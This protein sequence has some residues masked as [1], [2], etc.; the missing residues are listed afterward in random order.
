[1]FNDEWGRY[2]WKDSDKMR[3]VLV[4]EIPARVAADRTY[5]NAMKQFDK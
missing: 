4:E 5:Q 2:P 3:R 1:M